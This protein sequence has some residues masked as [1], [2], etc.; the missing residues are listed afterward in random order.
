MLEHMPIK[1]NRHV[2]QICLLSHVLS[3]KPASTHRVKPEGML[4]RD[5][6]R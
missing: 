4:F 5:I 2:L 6:F 3:G 1:L